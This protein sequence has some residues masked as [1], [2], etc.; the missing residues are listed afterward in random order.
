[1]STNSEI[2]PNVSEDGD[3]PKHV[4]IIMDGNGRWATQRGL[5]RLAGHRSGVDRV[6]EVVKACP[7]LGIHHLTLFAFSTENWKRSPEEVAGLMTLFRRYM[8]KESARLVSEGVRVRFLGE[9]TRLPVDIQNMIEGLEAQSASNDRFFLNIA[10]NYGARDEI[11]RAVKHLAQKVA[12]GD[13]DAEDVSESVVEGFLDTAGLP[14][15]CLIIR[16]SGELRI[17]NFLLWQAAYSEFVFV[18]ECWPD[19]TGDA[20]AKIV[21]SFA[22]RERR[23]GAA[24]V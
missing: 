5:P 8:T 4:A 16:T 14:D 6:R 18:E 10:L 19:F 21:G 11:T 20:F 7:D 1:M 13:L 15:P 23:F 9:R 22:K 12:A 17:S 3:G 2:S 24:A